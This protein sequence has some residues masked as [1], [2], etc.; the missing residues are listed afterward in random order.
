MDTSQHQKCHRSVTDKMAS[1]KF[2][3]D[4]WAGRVTKRAYV[5][6]EGRDRTVDEF[7][8]LI[9]FAKRREWFQLGTAN[10]ASAAKKA[11]AIY[12]TLANKGWEVAVAEFKHRALSRKENPSVGDFFKAIRG[13]V[14][15][16][17]N[18]PNAQTLSGYF[19][20]FRSIVAAIHSM[21]RP[22]S[23]FDYRHGGNAA[24]KEKVEAVPLSSITPAKIESWKRS[25][26]EPYLNQPA[27]LKQA[28]NTVNSHLRFARSL[29]STEFVKALAGFELPKPL[30]L[31]GVDMFD[32]S[33]SRYLSKI[34]PQ[35]LI[36]KA[37]DELA[38]LHPEQFKIVL[39]GIACGL[40]RNE[41]DKLQW[42]AVDF[43]RGCI[44]VE[45]SSY[46]K[47]K[48]ETST[49]EVPVDKDVLDYLAAYKKTAT[50]E[51]VVES[52]V[53]PRMGT[54][55]F[56]YRASNEF[57]K[58]NEWLCAHGVPKGKPLH[59]LRKEYGRLITEKYGI[60]A[61]SRLLRHAGIQ[62]TADHY[63]D[64]QRRLT[65]GIGAM[66]VAKA[67][68]NPPVETKPRKPRQKPDS[69][70]TAELTKKEDDV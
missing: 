14:A 49:G 55:Y 9:Q 43:S 21:P 57:G 13:A 53:A 10:G 30:P 35:D 60:Y 3:Q 61:A 24:W 33:S 23:R 29:F 15:A 63:A 12:S 1:S 19:S 5:D 67:P 32:R 66:L 28:K 7:Q 54:T 50:G 31:E 40:R 8:V 20:K 18:A 34:N 52:K 4:Y 6:R 46:F 38:V 51:F 45:V 11:A 59:T 37:K 65:P 48:A 62:I 22:K 69:A 17:T 68:E 47:P 26:I 70:V 44:R 42:S 56:H 58:L 64:D 36:T 39:L 25:Y 41:I 16:R 2:H 27:K